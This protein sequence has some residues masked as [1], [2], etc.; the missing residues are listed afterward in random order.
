[1][2]WLAHTAEPEPPQD[3]EPE[4]KLKIG[5]HLSTGMDLWTKTYEKYCAEFAVETGGVP[6]REHRDR[7]SELA[8][9]EIKLWFRQR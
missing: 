3:L 2:T 9:R 8:D 6:T 7:A 4:R 5:S 1:M